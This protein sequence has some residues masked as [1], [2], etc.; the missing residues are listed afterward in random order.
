MADGGCARDWLE[1]A[2]KSLADSG[3]DRY[4]P[5]FVVN[6]DKSLSERQFRVM[7]NNENAKKAMRQAEKRRLRNRTVRTSLKTVVRKAK[8]AAGQGDATTTAASVQLAVKKLDQA[9]AKGYIHKNKAARL[10]SRLAKAVAAK[11]SATKAD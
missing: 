8:A 2:G 3:C 7:P 11:A 1:N 6:P 10:K 9:A 4:N 5:R